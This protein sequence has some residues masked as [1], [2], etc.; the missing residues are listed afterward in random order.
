MLVWVRKLGSKQRTC[1]K[2]LVPASDDEDTSREQASLEDTKKS[3]QDGKNLPIVDKAH[4]KHT[5]TPCNDQERQPPAG[6]DLS[7]DIVRGQLK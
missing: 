5:E 1:L 2:L 7:D 6:T 4:A 3:S